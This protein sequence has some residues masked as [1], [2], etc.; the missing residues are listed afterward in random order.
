[1]S[2]AA[3]TYMSYGNEQGLLKR[4]RYQTISTSVCIRDQM[5]MVWRSTLPILETLFTGYEIQLG[6][7][8][9]FAAI[10]DVVVLS[11]KTF[12]SCKYCTCMG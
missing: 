3:Q 5:E 8:C 12:E 6:Y 1:M 7:V 11:L 2:L 9:L 10:K 4:F